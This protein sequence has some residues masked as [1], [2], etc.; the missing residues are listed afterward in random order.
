[1]V[2]GNKGPNGNMNKPKYAAEYFTTW[3]PVAKNNNTNS[4]CG[5]DEISN[6]SSGGSQFSAT[7]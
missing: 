6:T 7:G 3:E 2:K 5:A 4:K 1:M